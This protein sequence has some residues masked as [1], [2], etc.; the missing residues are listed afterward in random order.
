MIWE[1]GVTFSIPTFLGRYLAF[2]PE[3]FSVK[4]GSIQFTV[5]GE[6]H[7]CGDSGIPNDR[8]CWKIWE[9]LGSSKIPKPVLCNWEA[10]CKVQI[11]SQM[12]SQISEI[13]LHESNLVLQHASQINSVMYN[14]SVSWFSV[15]FCMTS[16]HLSLLSY[17]LEILRHKHVFVWLPELS[18][19]TQKIL[20]Q[21]KR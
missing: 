17:F 20:I 7:T 18:A 21:V 6:I 16:V 10:A 13:C 15:L 12:L 5:P 19:V 9:R 3:H 4:S 2:R 1:K 11:R 14:S 8:K